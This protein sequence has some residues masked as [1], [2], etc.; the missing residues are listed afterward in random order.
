MNYDQVDG[1]MSAA[2][3]MMA[4]WNGQTMA[5]DNFRVIVLTLGNSESSQS[6]R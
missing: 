5:R 6:Y 1:L 4:L 3:L 2:T